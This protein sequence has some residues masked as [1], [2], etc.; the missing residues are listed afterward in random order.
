[1]IMEERGRVT[2]WVLAMVLVAEVLLIY[3]K[4]IICFR[5][6][7]GH[8]LLISVHS[9]YVAKVS[10][11]ATWNSRLQRLFFVRR[12][13]FHVLEICL[14]SIASRTITFQPKRIHC[15]QV[16]FLRLIL[17]FKDSQLLDD[18]VS[19]SNLRSRAT[20]QHC[21]PMPLLSLPHDL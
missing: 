2:I 4:I 19:C 12:V 17:E 5:S 20:T 8:P 6:N 18:S 14:G 7:R 16:I 13:E 10:L 11:V 1:M 3:F 15:L 9:T 21:Q